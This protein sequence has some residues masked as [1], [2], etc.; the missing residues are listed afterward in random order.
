[1]KIPNHVAIILDGNGRWAKSKGMPRTYGHIKGCENLEKICSMAKE[2]GVKYLTVYAFSTENWKRSREEVD[3]L[4][5]LFRNY[6]KKCLKISAEN[7][8][9][10][11][12]IGDPRAFDEDLQQKIKELEEF[13]SQ[14]DELHFQIA[15]NY[16]S[17]DEIR[18]AVQDMARDVKSGVLN[19]EE[20]TEEKISDY[21]D[22]KG[23]PDPDLLIRTSGEERLSNY[24]LWQLA[25]TELYF[26]DVPWPD[27]DKEEF[28]RA[29][30]KY[31]GRDRRFGGVKEE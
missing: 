16:G 8:M 7:K 10:V 5:K 12:V 31:N 26:T 2:L 20:I 15:L 18:R 14:F 3:G 30:E 22:T 27:F 6:M 24:L 13:S 29:I 17:R 28:V 25:Y 21:L 4:M 19:P 11:R 1:M 9:R 23:L